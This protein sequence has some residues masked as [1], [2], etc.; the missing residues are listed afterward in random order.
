MLRAIRWLCLNKPNG[1]AFI[2]KGSKKASVKIQCESDNI[3]RS[4]GTENLYILNGKKLKSFRTKVP[5]PIKRILKV[6]DI[7]FQR[8]LESAF[9]FSLKPAQV[10]KELNKLVDLESIDKCHTALAKR[11]RK[12]KERLMVANKIIELEQQQ[13]TA[14]RW[15]PGLRLGLDAITPLLGG[16]VAGGSH[17]ARLGLLLAG[18]SQQAAQLNNANRAV[19]GAVRGCRAGRIANRAGNRADTLAGLCGAVRGSKSTLAGLSAV[20]IVPKSDDSKPLQDL[21]LSVVD[22][23]YE[24]NDLDTEI[25]AREKDMETKLGGF[26]PACG[27]IL[28]NK[29]LI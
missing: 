13:V 1:K 22:L 24:L 20:P 8:Q 15:V 29:S 27:G 10:T 18:G 25:K 19:Y 16:V 21:L 3:E 14:W 28:S 26:C 6:Q 2:R 4:V 23:G 12:A 17:I 5:S 7:N 11:H 9:W